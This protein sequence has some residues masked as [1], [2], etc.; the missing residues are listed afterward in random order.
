MKRLTIAIC[1]NMPIFTGVIENYLLEYIDDRFSLDCDVFN[2][3]ERLIKNLEQHYYHIYF[4]DIDMLTISGLDLARTIRSNDLNA[5]IIFFTYYTNY[6]KYIKSIFEVNPFDY[7]INP[8]TK[9]GLYKTIDRIIKFL[10]YKDDFFYYKKRKDSILISMRKI[11]YFEKHGRYVLI[12]TEDGLDKF[13]MTTDNLLKKLNNSFVQIHTSFI[14]NLNYLSQLSGENI[15]L[16]FYNDGK[17]KQQSLQISRKFRL[18]ARTK[19]NKYIE[20]NIDAD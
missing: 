18:D 13:I 9:Q 4:L 11:V 14:I 2:Q 6:T 7:L 20:K 5:Y 15:L 19:I 10:N 8:I 17:I 16:S 1:G 3:P 12:H